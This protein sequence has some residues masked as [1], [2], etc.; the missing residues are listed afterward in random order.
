MLYEVRALFVDGYVLSRESWSH[1]CRFRGR[2]DHCSGW[3]C[4]CL[5]HV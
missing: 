5:A 2:I 1:W 3:P 4:T